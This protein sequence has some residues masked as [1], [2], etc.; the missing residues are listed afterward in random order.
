MWVVFQGHGGDA[1][2]VQQTLLYDDEEEEEEERTAGGFDAPTQAYLMGSD[3]ESGRWLTH[4]A[5]GGPL[6]IVI[7]ICDN[8]NNSLGI[9]NYLLKDRKLCC[10]LL[11]LF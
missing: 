2:N 11:V 9:K 3:N 8:F 1:R 7:W 6:E 4:S 10:Y 5:S